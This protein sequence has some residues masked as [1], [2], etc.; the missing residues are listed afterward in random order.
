VAVESEEKL[1]GRTLPKPCN[2][3]SH[4]EQI[5]CI[6]TLGGIPDETQLEEVVE[7]S[8]PLVG[9]IQPSKKTIQFIKKAKKVLKNSVVKANVQQI[10]IY[11]N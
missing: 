7:L 11:G 9:M 5:F 4:L 8:G 2:S 3:S 6:W 1:H 10:K